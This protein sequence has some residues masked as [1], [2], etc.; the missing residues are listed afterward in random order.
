[1]KSPLRLLNP[2]LTLA[3]V[4][5]L[6]VLPCGAEEDY[7]EFEGVKRDSGEKTL[8]AP[9]T[10]KDATEFVVA[11]EPSSFRFSVV[12]GCYPI[13]DYNSGV[14]SSWSQSILASDGN[15][16]CAIS[17]H[18]GVD[19]QCYVIR[20]NPKTD[21]Q[22]RVLDTNVLISREPET[23]GHGKLHGRLDEYPKG[24]IIGATYWGM[25]PLWTVYKGEPWLGDVPG[26]HL[27]S[28]DIAKGTSKDLGVPFERDSWPMH[29][30]DTRRGIFYA[31]GYDKHFLA[32]DL[33]TKRPLY[34]AL[35]QPTVEWSS[36]ATLVDEITGNCYGTSRNRFVKYNPKTNKITYLEAQ[37]PAKPNQKGDTHLRCYTRRRTAEGAYICQTF[38]GTIFKFFPDTETT[39]TI[40]INWGE[41]YYCASM[42]LS[43]GGRYIYYTVDVHGS[44]YLHGSPIVQY[45]LKEKKRKVIAFLH[46]HFETAYNYVFGGSYSVTLNE[47]G[48]ELFIVWNGKFKADKEGESFGDPT[49]MVVEIPASERQE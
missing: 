46:P 47:D 12:K 25:P 31:V 32:Y 40:D 23:Y 24:Y 33:N 6:N 42:A 36:R 37:L 26:G 45:D 7:V 20:Y 3:F 49:F 34:A 16:Y 30:T 43:P 27:F 19:G 15:Y 35:P 9:E 10:L 39:E 41:G 8:A 2:L 28:I 5:A 13:P 22:T 17:N 44:A 29:A 4:A 48:S 18:L 11:K 1:M 21:E 38:D 14:W